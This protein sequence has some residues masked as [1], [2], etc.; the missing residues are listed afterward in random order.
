MEAIRI[1]FGCAILLFISGFI[2][3]YISPSAL[4]PAVK[5][6][7]G[8]TTGLAMY[9]YFFLAGREPDEIDGIAA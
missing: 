5:I 3:G 6:A 9:S 1:V 4:H 7:V 8:V 2:E